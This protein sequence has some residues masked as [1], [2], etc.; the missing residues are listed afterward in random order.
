MTLHDE[1]SPLHTH[2]Y[3]LVNEGKI[4]EKD[5]LL[6]HT[7]LDPT[8]L[9]LLFQAKQV[10]TKLI[11]LGEVRQQVLR[12]GSVVGYAPV[13]PPQVHQTVQC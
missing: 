6:H 5:A 10:A 7:T 12:H 3:P 11:C 1:P 4:E 2:T 8:V 13:V 9:R